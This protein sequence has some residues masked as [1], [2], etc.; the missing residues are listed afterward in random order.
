M[1]EKLSASQESLLESW[2]RAEQAS[3]IVPS[4]TPPPQTVLQHSKVGCPALKNTYGSAPLT[5]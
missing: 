5:T 3:G 4:L 2:A 1:A